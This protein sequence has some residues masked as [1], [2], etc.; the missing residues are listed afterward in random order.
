MA[1]QMYSAAGFSRALR[2][3]RRTFTHAPL[4]H[5]VRRYRFLALF[6]LFGSVSILAEIVIVTQVLPSDWPWL[7]RAISGFLV[8]LCISFW[9]NATLNFRVAKRRL[10]DTFLR[11]AV[12]SLASFAL[13]AQTMNLVQ[14]AFGWPYATSRAVCAGS[15][16]LLAY[17]VHRRLTFQPPKNFGIA[18][19]ASQ[20][21]RVRRIFV[22]IGRACDHIH[23]DLVDTTMNPAAHKVDLS[24]IHTA[25]KCWPK[26][27]FALH[28]MSKRPSLWLDATQSVIDWYLFHIGIEEN[29][30][31][32][33][34]W[35]HAHGKKVGVV[36]HES[37][38]IES[39]YP[40]LPHVDFVMVLGIREPGRS[41]QCLTE[42]AIQV[43]DM[44]DR[45]RPRYGYELMFDGSVN[46]ST[47]KRIRANYVV[48][49]SG[50]LKD[51]KPVRAIYSLKA[52]GHDGQ[53]VA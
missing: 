23:I 40:Y 41:G 27:P 12:V 7:G 37:D 52:G 36:W 13:N 5:V 48:A 31:S 25:R 2:K 26:L 1:Y 33:I 14:D 24:Q 9:L 43:T 38:L 6:T 46:P 4:A 44:L 18:V 21:E 30:F 51:G 22:A 42:R 16:F 39:L 49:A 29:L 28:V 3:V 15:F 47:V 17:V 20:G 10:Y 45:L 34:A 53:R 32:L 50:V 35:C 8:G 19:Y 11:F